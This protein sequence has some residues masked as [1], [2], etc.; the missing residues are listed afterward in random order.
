MER[1]QVVLAAMAA[2]GPGARFNPVQV[3]KNLFLID[4]EIPD[5]VAGPHFNFEPYDHGPFDKAVYEVLDSLAREDQVSIDRTNRYRTYTLTGSGFERGTA[6]LG[7]LPEPVARYMREAARWVR[8]LTFGR[9]LA[10]IYQHYPDM[11]VNSIVPN[12]ASRY[13][14]ASRLF[15]IPSFLSGMARTFDFMGTLDEYQP[16]WRDRRHDALAIHGDW[17]AV[18]NDLEVA[19]ESHF[20]KRPH[21]S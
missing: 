3:Q 13:P 18:G 10:P 8:S 15:P 16:G 21:E 1:Y 4:R 7:E 19:M 2:G 12:M 17:A 14:R 9:L 11:E 6:V 5:R 20:W